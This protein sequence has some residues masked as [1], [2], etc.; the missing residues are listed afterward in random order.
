[1]LL[2]DSLLTI[3]LNSEH[4]S[5]NLSQAVLLV[6]YACLNAIDSDDCVQAKTPQNVLATKAEV[7]SF[8]EK[9][10]LLLQKKGY[11]W[12]EEKRQKMKQNLDNIFLKASLTSQEVRTLHGVLNFL[13]KEDEKK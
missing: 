1:M 2:A 11:Y 4:T 6:G 13:S 5:L 7:S 12:I 10:D 9:M 8:L 3:P